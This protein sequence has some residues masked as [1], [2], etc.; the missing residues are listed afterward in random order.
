MAA[1]YAAAAAA[2]AVGARCVWNTSAGK[3]IYTQSHTCQ[4]TYHSSDSTTVT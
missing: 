3:H 2:A 4:Y 1:G